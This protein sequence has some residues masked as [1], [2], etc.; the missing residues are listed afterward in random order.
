MIS[1]KTFIPVLGVLLLVMTGC[2][3]AKTSSDAPDRTSADRVNVP[4]TDSAKTTQ[5]DANSQV[6]R[7]QLNSDIRSVIR[8]SIAVK[9]TAAMM[10]SPVKYAAN[11]KPIYP[12]V[13]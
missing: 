5:D 10:T 6:R 13:L 7:D 3:A 4:N 1:P 12:L 9:P 11:W 8:L 2:E